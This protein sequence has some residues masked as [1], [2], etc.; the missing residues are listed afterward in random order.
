VLNLS[1]C[2]FD[3]FHLQFYAV[4]YKQLERLLSAIAQHVGDSADALV[5]EMSFKLGV[6]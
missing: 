1:L 5:R 3:A 6:F 2:L 4:M